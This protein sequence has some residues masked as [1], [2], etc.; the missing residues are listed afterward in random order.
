M[1]YLKDYN[2]IKRRFLYLG[3]T[4][5]F[6]LHYRGPLVSRFVPNHKSVSRNPALL[7]DKVTKEVEKGFTAGP[8]ISPPFCPFIVSPG[9][10]STKIGGG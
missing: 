5:G 9:R 2:P 4:H 7:T 3:L 10:P 1:Q 8:F 6:K